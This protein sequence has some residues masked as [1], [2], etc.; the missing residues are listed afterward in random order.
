[1]VK[2]EFSSSTM[3]TNT[4]WLWWIITAILWLEKNENIVFIH[5]YLRGGFS[6]KWMNESGEIKIKI[7]FRWPSIS[8][9]T[10]SLNDHGGIVITDQICYSWLPLICNIILMIH[11]HHEN[12]N[13]NNTLQNWWWWWLSLHWVNTLQCVDYENMLSMITMMMMMFQWKVK[14]AT[15]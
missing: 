14:N 15:F 11:H 1:M 12:N 8:L 2:P 13:N 4:W 5:Q 6:V 7:K 9:N 3:M 10:S